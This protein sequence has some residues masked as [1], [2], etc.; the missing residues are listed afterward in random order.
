MKIIVGLGNPGLGYRRTRHNLGFVVVGALARAR[1]M[2]FR[3]GRFR[4]TQAQGEIGKEQ[5]LLVRPQTFMNLSGACVGPLVRRAAC[6][7]DDLLVICDDVNL[8]LGK[9]RLRRRGSAGGHQGLASIIQHLGSEEF[10][11][12]R[13]G[14]GEPPEGMD[15][16]SYVL[17]TFRR[18]ERL[19]VEE[20][21]TQAVQVAETWVYHGVE[22]AMNRFN[23]PPEK[24]R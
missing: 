6:H 22:E 24:S 17:G 8:E 13:L 19:A 5:V 4:C 2:S 18:A 10:P 3:R 7:L 14:A 9:L 15:M 12:L 23:R 21:V 11:R 1:G 16:T 20:L